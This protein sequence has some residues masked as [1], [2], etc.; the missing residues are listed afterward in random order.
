MRLTLNA[1]GAHELGVLVTLEGSKQVGEGGGE[2]SRPAS[3]T[4]A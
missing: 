4:Y 1:G 2:E 3:S